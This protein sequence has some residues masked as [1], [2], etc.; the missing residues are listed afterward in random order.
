MVFSR[1]LG[2][3]SICLFL[4]SGS[5]LAQL[6]GYKITQWFEVDNSGGSRLQNYQV[7]VV[8]DH[9]ELVSQGMGRAD[10][11]DIR[12]T[13]CSLREIPFAIESGANT[14]VMLL[15]VRMPEIP[16]AGF[17]L[18][19]VHSGNPSVP[20]RS[21]PRQ[22]FEFYDNFSGGLGEWFRTAGSSVVGGR[23]RPVVE[24]ISMGG[25]NYIYNRMPFDA[26]QGSAVVEC[27]TRSSASEKGG[28]IIFLCDNPE[29]PRHYGLQH[30]TRSVFPNGRPDGDVVFRSSALPGDAAVL[31]MEYKTWKAN[32]PVLNQI[33][34]APTRVI[35]MVR[36][37]LLDSA[38]HT[39]AIQTDPTS[40]FR[41]IGFSRF[42]EGNGD[43]DVEW[44]RVR[45][46]AS[47]IPQTRLLDTRVTITGN[48]ALCTKDSVRLSGSTGF[49][50]YEWVG[51]EGN[52]S[53]QL[54]IRNPGTYHLKMQHKSGC[55]I[56]SPDFVVTMDQ[57]PVA[58]AETDSVF[59]ICEGQSITLRA[60]SGHASYKWYRG[61]G[62]NRTLI[63]QESTA[64]VSA[65][66]AYLLIVSSPNGCMDSAR[67]FIHVLKSDAGARIVTETGDSVMC[68]GDSL[69]LTARPDGGRYKWFRDDVLLFNES[70][71]SITVRVAGRYKLEVHIGDDLSCASSVTMNVSVKPR[72]S[73]SLPDAIEICQGDSATVDAGGP[74][75][76]Y[77]WSTGHTTRSVSLTS[78]GRYWV[79]VSNGPKCT[80][81]VGFS[82]R[83][84]EFPI[85]V[86]RTPQGQYSICDGD[87]L[88]LSLTEDYSRV[89]WSTG[90]TTTST[91]VTQAGTYSV[92]VVSS[93]GCHGAASLTL[94]KGAIPPPTIIYEGPPELCPGDIGTLRLSDSY[95][96]YLWST[97][98]E[99]PT[100]SIRAPGSYSV[101]VRNRGCVANASII[102]R[103]APQPDYQVVVP[104]D[105]TICGDNIPAF[106]RVIKVK[107]NLHLPRE[108]TARS[109]SSIFQVI[110]DVNQS[111]GND[112]L[113]I[114]VLVEPGDSRG[115]QTGRI[116]LSD[117]CGWWHDV[118]VYV[119]I[120]YKPVG[121]RLNY[122]GP[123]ISSSGIFLFDI[124]ADSAVQA[125]RLRGTDF[126]EL[127][128]NHEQ[129][130]LQITGATS[131]IATTETSVMAMGGGATLKVSHFWKSEDVVASVEVQSLVGETLYPTIRLVDGRGNNDCIQVSVDP[132]PLDI[133]LLPPGCFLRTIRSSTSADGLISISPT[134]ASEFVNFEFGLAAPGAVSV[135]IIDLTGRI[136]NVY[137]GTLLRGVHHLSFPAPSSGTYMLRLIIAGRAEHHTFIV[138]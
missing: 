128:V 18:I 90:D 15:W 31:N 4:G 50:S 12:V 121:L 8:V 55:S 9:K 117:Q 46:Y 108:V 138:Q 103:S 52:D 16:A 78:E 17:T 66:D 96:F 22:T 1:F 63:G 62:Q 107:N 32:E 115:G 79:R 119:D 69:V 48:L 65:S 70:F 3:L 75:L 82:V 89:I 124:L 91:V 6:A 61:I 40:V 67:F 105:T 95:E 136:H 38:R 133:V 5:L 35:S 101:E 2:I 134:P 81:S 111:N 33:T 137:E 30:D 49:L 27:V 123:P 37:S 84:V 83:V 76:S 77:S 56:R 73:L 44:V 94:D 131:S 99:T 47:A 19:G 59:T 135:G 68:E 120:G 25:S 53:R 71:K 72:P 42:G 114:R 110:N 39:M 10:A 129:S 51:P 74:Y 80:D 104:M 34:I 98:A 85:P 86:I 93:A 92:E 60:V 112:S 64:T 45:K 28:T 116:T 113:E 102:I 13:D 109:M 97:G 88:R 118:Y 106:F 21:N 11:A 14:S 122:S 100:L 7:R 20:A 29:L 23:L 58:S 87:T 24:D 26:L 43:M 41:Y 126:L 127:S 132:T 54:T 130:A 125:G 36:L 57:S